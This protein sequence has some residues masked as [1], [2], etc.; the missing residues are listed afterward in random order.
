MGPVIEKKWSILW[1]TTAVTALIFLDNTVMPVAL[2]TIEQGLAFSQI[3]LIWV[4]N[5]YLLTLTMLMVI[6]GRICD[7]LGV[8]KT[9]FWGLFIFAM[10]SCLGG[11]SL[12]QGM[13]I[14]GRVLQGVGGALLVPTT[15]ALI[16][17]T[18]PAGKRAKAIGI[19]TGISS[20]FLIL[21][22]VVGGLFT[23]YLNWRGIFWIN[24]P[25]V[26]FAFVMA[27]KKLLKTSKKQETFHVLGAIPLA[28]SILGIV[29]ALM[30]GS[31][32]G[33][34]SPWT[35]GF[36]VM[37]PI[38]FLLF[39][40]SSS[41]TQHPIM[42]FSLF[43]YPFFTHANVC[44]FLT[45]LIVMA[46]VLWAIYFQEELGFTAAQA[47]GLI[48]TAT[49][50]VLI[51]APIAGILGDRYGSVWP[52][53]A[54]FLLLLF[55][56]LWFAFFPTENAIIRLLP[57]LL[58]FGCGIPLIM[59]PA[60]AGAMTHIPAEK[61]GASS[62]LTSTIRQL[63]STLG[64]ALMS[65]LYYGVAEA[66]RPAVAFSTLS[67]LGAFIAVIGFVYACAFM[68]NRLYTQVN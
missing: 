51:V 52:M 65:A 39:L 5:S 28:L 3:G 9:Y 49:L 14:A 20:L 17:Q 37:C 8:R 2:P 23:Q 57:A 64:I 19:N 45:Q 55:S 31:S 13:L 27:Q 42:E 63:S 36:L 44:M 40:W 48:F 7:L 46:T 67:F 4:V 54:G 58:P 30:Q 29:V 53:G 24:I 12:S 62:A 34:T 32:W 15:G 60:V 38:F 33:W 26:A 35:L 6:G 50:P 16:L 68:K 56:L 18:F 61:L 10:G 47:G 25:V 41:H 21:G 22:P 66:H 59:S 1:I 43:K 11:I